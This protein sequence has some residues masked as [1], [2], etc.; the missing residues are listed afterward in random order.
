MFIKYQDATG[1]LI[2]IEVSEVIGEVSIEIDKEMANRNRRE[3]RW[4]NSISRMEEAG[5]QFAD[6]SIDVAELLLENEANRKL[7]AAMN[8]L[9]PQQKELIRQVFFEERSLV[10]IARET[11]VT[12]GAIWNR[13]QKIYKRLKFFLE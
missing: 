8:K 4:H 10:E 2:E 13:L 11:G 1:N 7:H 12:V 3:T 9:L 5:V 6:E